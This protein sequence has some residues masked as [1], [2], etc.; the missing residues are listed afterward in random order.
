MKSVRRRRDESEE[1]RKRKR[2]S[3]VERR[4]LKVKR[5]LIEGIVFLL[6]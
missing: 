3:C 6:F 5:K 2:R 1:N 4:S